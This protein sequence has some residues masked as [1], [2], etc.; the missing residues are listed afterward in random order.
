MHALDGKTGVK[1]WES[2]IHTVYRDIKPVIFD[3]RVIITLDTERSLRALAK[4][5]GQILWE[6]ASAEASD[7]IHALARDDKLLFVGSGIDPVRIYAVDPETGKAVWEQSESFPARSLVSIIYED[8]KL[9]ALFTTGVYVLSPQTGEVR[10]Q[11]KI[12]IAPYDTPSHQGNL[13]FLNAREGI[14]AVQLDSSMPRWAFLPKCIKDANENEG[15]TRTGKYFLYAPSPVGDRTFVTG[16]CHR[17]FALD[18]K[19]GT[20]LWEYAGGSIGTISQLVAIDKQGYVMFSDG[21]IRCFD[22]ASGKEIGR[23]VTRLKDTGWTV[24]GQGLAVT[25]GWLYATFGNTTLYAFN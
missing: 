7:S 3:D 4:S 15:P 18:T 21:S 2:P 20:E 12:N 1:L 6:T 11:A 9:Y 14:W 25:S 24:K 8:D 16:G 22:L 13:L 23:L 17:I 10:S 5:T 19:L